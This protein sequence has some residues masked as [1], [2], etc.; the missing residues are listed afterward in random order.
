MKT[1]IEKD[2]KNRTLVLKREHRRR[3]YK[4]NMR[5]TDSLSERLFWISQL[6]LVGRSSSRTR[7]TNRCT[8]TGR[9]KGKL[10]SWRMSRI[11][12]RQKALA[13]IL[14]GVQKASW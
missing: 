3:L 1:K 12:F 10:K 13:G 7:I 8:Y 14:P 6:D 4:A 5:Q 2:N 11:Q 9:A